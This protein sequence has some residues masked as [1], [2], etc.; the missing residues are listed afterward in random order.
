MK[1]K[2]VFTWDNL[3]DL[4]ICEAGEWSHSPS[5]SSSVNIWFHWAGT[6]TTEELFGV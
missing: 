1:N 3:M 4:Q 2:V 6:F 5:L